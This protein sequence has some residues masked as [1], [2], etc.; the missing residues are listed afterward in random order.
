MNEMSE[1]LKEYKASLL[2]RRGGGQHDPHSQIPTNILI[3]LAL[4]VCRVSS[5]FTKLIKFIDTRYQL[6]YYCFL[7]PPPRMMQQ[8]TCN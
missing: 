7:H 2:D 5:I 3:D 6:K 8:A 1:K 4:T